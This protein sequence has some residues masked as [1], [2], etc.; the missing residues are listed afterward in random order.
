MAERFD[1]KADPSVIRKEMFLV[2]LDSNETLEEFAQRVQFM[3]MDA[4]PGAKEETIQQISV[5]VFLRGLPDKEAARSSSDKC[6]KTIQKALKYVKNA[7]NTQ[8]AIFNKPSIPHHQVSFAEL[9]E[10]DLSVRSTSETEATKSSSF[11]KRSLDT[12]MMEQE[13]AHLRAKISQLESQQNSSDRPSRP[14]SRPVTPPPLTRTNTPPQNP[15]SQS[16][17]PSQSPYHSS[18]SP[19]RPQNSPYRNQN[20]PYRPQNSP[21]RNQNSP[22]RPQNTSASTTYSQA[23]PSHGNTAPRSFNS[24]GNQFSRMGKKCFRCGGMGHFASECPSPDNQNCSGK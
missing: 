12:I 8:K 21:Y 5:E 4:H 3:A 13:L 23:S 19:Y 22:Y 1:I 17:F 11:Q 15:S 6:P 2:K 24:P 10:P 7:I 16:Q 9:D 18:N 20:S 14:F